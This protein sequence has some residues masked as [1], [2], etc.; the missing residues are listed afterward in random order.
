MEAAGSSRMLLQYLCSKTCKL[1]N[2]VFLVKFT[3]QYNI[4]HAV[5][6]LVDTQ[7]QLIFI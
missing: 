6:V 1:Y 4:L 7:S 3:Y 2:L 5:I